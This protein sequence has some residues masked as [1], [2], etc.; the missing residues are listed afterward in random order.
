MTHCCNPFHA[1]IWEVDGHMVGLSMAPGRGCQEINTHPS[2]RTVN[3]TQPASA[4]HPARGQSTLSA[5]LALPRLSARS[6]VP[7][8]NDGWHGGGAPRPPRP[9]PHA[10]RVSL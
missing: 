10:R 5:L 7:Q 6:L 9:L 8:H 1:G 4:R 3:I 2:W